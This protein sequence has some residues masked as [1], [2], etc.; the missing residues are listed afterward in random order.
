MFD[1]WERVP[2]QFGGPF[3]MIYELP[4]QIK[5]T[6]LFENSFRYSDKYTC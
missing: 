5:S 2:G 4:F 1:T 6:L 3:K